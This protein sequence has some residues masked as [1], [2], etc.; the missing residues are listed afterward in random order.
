MCVVCAYNAL[1]ESIDLLQSA[2]R[3]HSIVLQL[4]QALKP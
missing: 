1:K 3:K 2:M 4:L